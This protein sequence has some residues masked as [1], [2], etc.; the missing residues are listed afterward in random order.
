MKKWILLLSVLFL[1]GLLS[2]CTPYTFDISYF[3][4]I[5]SSETK[6]GSVD[7]EPPTDTVTTESTSSSAAVASS[8]VTSSV[9]AS[10]VITSS[11]SS[12]P[13]QNPES[14]SVNISESYADSVLLRQ[15]QL[16]D[17]TFNMYRIENPSAGILFFELP[18]SS[19]E[20]T[21]SVY[22]PKA[23]VWSDFPLTEGTFAGSILKIRFSDG[24][25]VF[26][27][28]PKSY[29][30][31]DCNVIRQTGLTG[32][33]T[34]VRK[35]GSF[36][37]Q[38]ASSS[39]GD[40]CD[41]A[42]YVGPLGTSSPTEGIAWTD[43]ADIWA[44]YTDTDEAKW[45][46]DGYYYTTP[47]NYDPSGADCYYRCTASYI[48][49]LMWEQFD[50]FPEAKLLAL[51]TL[52]TVMRNQEE[53][54]CW[55]T[56]PS[57]DWLISDY[58][59]YDGFY[60]TRFNTDL[61][62]YTWK[63]CRSLN[64]VLYESQLDAYADFFLNYAAENHHETA[65][66]WLIADYGYDK[67]HLLPHTA[68]NHHASEIL[69]LYHLSSLLQRSDLKELADKM[70]QGIRDTGMDWVKEDHN[71]HYRYNPDGT[72]GGEDYPRLTYNDL[73]ALQDYL[74]QTTGTPDETIAALMSEKWIYICNT[75]S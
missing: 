65:S 28:M 54:G 17:S 18:L 7:T 68:L 41:C 15:Y 73:S 75:G 16:A 55:L 74:I 36:Y 51:G 4:T 22:D 2:G 27:D 40:F 49:R 52:D 8:A 32:S 11:V 60:D 37:L 23:Q 21:V 19:S 33:V 5:P 25:G 13:V 69:T 35:N 47:P 26:C 10:S 6:A 53:N 44:Y 71:L 1:A 3:S 63:I 24:S 9:A 50:V 43:C 45:C 14:V 59:I 62:E 30:L 66:G 42:L 72:Y 34:I 29:D 67:E 48:L 57:C 64:T 20:G 12:S 39:K 61:M 31:L 70:L 58:H 46:F 38:C 56:G